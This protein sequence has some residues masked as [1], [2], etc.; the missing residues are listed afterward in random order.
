VLLGGGCGDDVSGAPPPGVPASL[1]LVGTAAGPRPDGGSISCGLDLHI[2]LSGEIQRTSDLVDYAGVHGGDVRR[3]TVDSTGA[4]FGFWAD[5]YWPATVVRLILPDSLELLLG[6]TTVTDS[7]FWREI[8]WLPG[9]R[10]PGDPG[11]GAWTCAPFDI[12][13]GGYVDTFGIVAGTWQ[14]E[15]ASA[16]AARRAPGHGSV[17]PVAAQQLSGDLAL[18]EGDLFQFAPGEH[19]GLVSMVR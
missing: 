14:L 2:E 12:N 13:E 16:L 6:D 9:H 8:A 15:P 7:R 11:S 17:G 10:G 1:H 4:G 5:V 19:R 18:G 3:T